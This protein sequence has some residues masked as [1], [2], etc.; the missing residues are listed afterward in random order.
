MTA[1]VFLRWLADEH[2]AE[3][4]TLALL[5]LGALRIGA[6]GAHVGVASS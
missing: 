4:A 5:R 1:L 2:G 6:S 3:G